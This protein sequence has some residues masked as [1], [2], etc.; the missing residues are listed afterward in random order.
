MTTQTQTYYKVL[1][2]RVRI[3]ARNVKNALL[4]EP[5]TSTEGRLNEISMTL[6]YLPR[7]RKLCAVNSTGELESRLG[8]LI[9]SEQNT[10]SKLE[11]KE[12]GSG[13]IGEMSGCLRDI[14][15]QRKYALVQFAE[16]IR[17]RTRFQRVNPL[18]VLEQ[19]VKEQ[20]KEARELLNE[21]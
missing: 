18:D 20:L 11:S 12:Y 13:L 16:E 9:A 15:V 17:T 5:Y 14:S 21:D 4:E 3:A 2:T 7:M 19:Y 6:S 10:V 8:S 1:A